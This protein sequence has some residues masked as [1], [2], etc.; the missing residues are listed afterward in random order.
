MRAVPNTSKTNAFCLG[1]GFQSWLVRHSPCLALVRPSF[2][3]DAPKFCDSRR[4]FVLSI[5]CCKRKKLP[6]RCASRC[7]WLRPLLRASPSRAQAS[8]R[9]ATPRRRASAAKVCAGA[10]RA[11]AG[12]SREETAPAAGIDGSRRT[13]RFV[14]ALSRLRQATFS[15]RLSIAWRRTVRLMSPTAIRTCDKRSP[16]C[17]RPP[18]DDASLPDEPKAVQMQLRLPVPASLRDVPHGRLQRRCQ[19]REEPA[20]AP[21]LSTVVAL[22]PFEPASLVAA[23]LDFAAQHLRAAVR[24]ERPTAGWVHHRRRVP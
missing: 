10:R 18:T 20:A 5:T 7:W 13:A 24:N 17:S 15:T 8:G 6:W 19:E 22:S 16:K 1:F 9:C 23:P 21:P 2:G 3:A 4:V 12:V 14:H 11:A